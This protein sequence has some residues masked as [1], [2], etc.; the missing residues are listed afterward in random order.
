MK[1]LRGFLLI[2][3]LVASQGCALGVLANG[4]KG[5]NAIKH[6]TEIV[7][8]PPGA[9]IEINNRYIGNT[10][11]TVEIHRGYT[12]MKDDYFSPKRITGFEAVKITAYPEPPTEGV[13]YVQT[14]ILDSNEPTPYNLSFTMWL[15][16]AFVRQEREHRVQEEDRQRKT[17][18]ALNSWIGH[19][20]TELLEQ[21]GPPTQVITN[22]EQDVLAYDNSVQMTVP[23][24][25]AGQR[26]I[27]KSGKYVM[28]WIDAKEKIYKVT[29]KD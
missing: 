6:M 11:L 12:W 13:Y 24:G 1:F 17:Y 14:K 25:S 23:V 5:L 4:P 22:K 8:D 18:E 9:R 3:L 29:W 20:K 15:E 7:S 26:L 27:V 2:V 19:T 21:W 16:P 10:P 28:F